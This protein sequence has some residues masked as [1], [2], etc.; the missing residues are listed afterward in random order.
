MKKLAYLYNAVTDTNDTDTSVKLAQC[1]VSALATK[2]DVT[3]IVDS[4][5]AYKFKFPPSIKM[6]TIK[7]RWFQPTD[8]IIEQRKLEEWCKKNIDADIAIGFCNGMTTYSNALTYMQHDVNKEVVHI[9]MSSL[10]KDMYR[11]ILTKNVFKQAR[12]KAFYRLFDYWEVC[13]YTKLA[14]RPVQVLGLYDDPNFTHKDLKASI[15]YCPDIDYYKYVIEQ[16]K[17]PS[18]KFRLF[19]F[20]YCI[21]A[22]RPDSW[23]KWCNEKIVDSAKDKIYVYRKHVIDGKKFSSLIPAKEY[24]NRIA[25]SKFTFVIPSTLTSEVSVIRVNESI[26][27]NCIP[28]FK[29]DNNIEKVYS[30]ETCRFIRENLTYDETKYKTVNDFVKALEP[31]YDELLKQIY[32]LDFVKKGLALVT[33]DILKVIDA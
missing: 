14:G 31:R 3:F 12:E 29:D 15:K 17:L 7:R 27:R 24:Y 10:C 13:D 23:N 4:N 26:R 8:Y 9:R 6:L 22:Y 5:V 16:P 32:E 20:G 1:F 28:L 30:A 25:Q 21:G 2:Y 33:D 18:K 19:T 11:L